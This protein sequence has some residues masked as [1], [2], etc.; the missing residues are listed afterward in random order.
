MAVTGTDRTWS[1]QG[2]Q[3]LNDLADRALMPDVARGQQMTAVTARTIWRSGRKDD[4]RNARSN[5][6]LI[7]SNAI[8]KGKAQQSADI[9]PHGIKRVK[10]I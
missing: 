3:Q 5:G 8:R 1:K 6:R 4:R 9:I 2:Y 10:V 7:S